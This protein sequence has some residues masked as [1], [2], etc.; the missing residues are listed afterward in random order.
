LWK[1]RGQGINPKTHL[2]KKFKKISGGM[3]DEKK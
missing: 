1:G 2:F 3:V